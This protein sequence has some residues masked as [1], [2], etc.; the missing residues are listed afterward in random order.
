LT[1]NNSFKREKIFKQ[2][3]NSNI[4]KKTLKLVNFLL[5]LKYK[6]K[7]RMTH[8]QTE[9]QVARLCLNL[10]ISTLGSVCLYRIMPHFKDMFIKAG[11]R[12]VDMSKQDKHVM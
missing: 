6:K 8:V 9:S 3:K 4:K 2:K 1:C 10:V 12:G 5:R 7:E 11:L